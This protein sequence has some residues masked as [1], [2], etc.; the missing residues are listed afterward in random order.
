MTLWYF[1]LPSARVPLFVTHKP[2]SL[3]SFSDIYYYYYYYYHHHR[4]NHT[5]QHPCA[6]KP[7]PIP[8]YRWVPKIKGRVLGICV[9]YV[10]FVMVLFFAPHI[11]RVFLKRIF[12]R[13]FRKFLATTP[14]AKIT[15]EFM[16]S[17]LSFQMILISRAKFSRFVIFLCLS[18]VK[19]MVQGNCPFNCK[20]CFI[21]SIDKHHIIIIIIIIIIFRPLH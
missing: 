17:S 8:D 1:D 15:K 2:L 7:S 4:L 9:L 16:D 12:S 5:S 11:R 21:P 20:C 14:S 19:G 6:G 3:L 18:F 13:H 10:T